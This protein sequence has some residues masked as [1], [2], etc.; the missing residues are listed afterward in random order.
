MR[1]RRVAALAK[2]Y[3]RDSDT[4]VGTAH[5]FFGFGFFALLYCHDSLLNLS[6]ATNGTECLFIFECNSAQDSQPRVSFV[7]PARTGI[8]VPVASALRT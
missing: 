3:G 5:A 2:Y 4:V 7:F 8:G 6:V 1:Y